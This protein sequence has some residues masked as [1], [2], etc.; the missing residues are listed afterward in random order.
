MAHM[1]QDH[2]KEIAPVIKAICKKYGVKA[3][4]SVR[5]HST[6]CL[7]IKSGKLDFGD[8]RQVNPYWLESHYEDKVLEFLKEAKGALYGP[9][10]FDKSEIQSD[11]FFCSHYIE[12]N[13]GKYDNPY[14]LID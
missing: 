1:S 9:R 7:N 8:T 10:Y 11:Y 14:V 3:S 4:L 6:L 12:I 13:V 5:H 2:K